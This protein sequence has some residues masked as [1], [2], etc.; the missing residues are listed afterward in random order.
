MNKG[1]ATRQRIIEAAAPIFNRQG[2]AGASM[3]DVM[4]AAGLEK[5]G[6]YRHF[7]SKEELAAESFRYALGQ[8][9]KTRTNDLEHVHGAIA[10]LRFL[11]DRFVE[12]PSAIPGGCP[13]LNTAI[14]ADDGNKALR[15][16]VR[17]GIRSWKSRLAKIVED[18]QRSGEIRGQVSAEQAANAIV[19]MLEGSL[20]ISR[21]EGSRTA[22]MDARTTLDILIGGFAVEDL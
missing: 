22:L 15:K 6:I 5:G 19:A 16:L 1:E 3:Q 9:V 10:K 13:I 12:L 7:A 18:G 17:E 8:S 21:I 11:V 4:E 20:M 14:D 2:F